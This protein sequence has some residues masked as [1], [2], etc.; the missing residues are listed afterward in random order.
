[1]IGTDTLKYNFIDKK[2][3]FFDFETSCLNLGIEYNRIWQASWI[4]YQGYKLVETHDYFLK[5]DNFYISPGA[6]LA[7]RFNPRNVEEKGR[8]PKEILEIFEKYLYDPQY[9]I[10]GQNILGF[11]V[12]LHAL[13]R[14]SFGLK[15]DYS[16]VD[17]LIDIRA[18]AVAY[19]TNAKFKP[20]A[21]FLAQQYRFLNL[22]QKGLKTNLTQ[23]CNDLNIPVDPNKMHDALEDVKKSAE[24][25][26]GLVKLLEI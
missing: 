24:V 4:V 22:R 15:P 7:T 14:K 17:R 6:A 16:Y 18:L 3:V 19:K 8:D 1:M 12:Y 2:F 26:Q 21:N 23:L 9:I 11:D 10:C 25:F 20:D 13:W 5:W